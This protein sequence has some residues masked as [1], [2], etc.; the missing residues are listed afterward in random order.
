MIA[1]PIRMLK[2]VK[3]LISEPRAPGASAP[4]PRDWLL[5][6][7]L[8]CAVLVESFLTETAVWHRVS[9]LVSLALVMTL[10]WRRVH[11]LGMVILAFGATAMVHAVALSQGVTWMGFK[12]NIAVVILPYALLRWASGRES[13]IGLAIIAVSLA[14]AMVAED[15]SWGEI[16]G[17]SLFL[18]FPSALGASVRYQDS[19]QRRS[20]E[21][22]RLSERERLARELHDTVAHHVSAI[23]IQAQAGRTLAAQRPQASLEALDIIEEAASRTLAEMRLIVRALREDDPAERSPA[24]SL[25]DI[26]QLALDEAC[27]LQV[28]VTMKGNLTQ[29][30]AMLE[31]TLFRLAQES[32]TNAAR[33]ANDAQSVTIVLEGDD[34]E[35]RLRVADDGKPVTHQSESGFGLRG[36]AER[37]AL[38]GGTLKAGPGTQR[39]WV[40]EATIP[41]QVAKAREHSSS[42]RR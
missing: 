37:V 25:V 30:N 7:V 24:A 19:A 17:A 13:I 23:A 11:P 6:A 12:A 18:L 20:Q 9:S 16:I 33:H 36:M 39:G 5:V 3:H 35:V 10:P 21:Q 22:V 34:Q 1:L 29:L 2:T 26:K 28:S 40:V 8:L 27:P 32:I 41:K 4:L 31:T 15:H 42:R 38:N 14:L